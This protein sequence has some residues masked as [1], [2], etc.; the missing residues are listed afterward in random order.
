MDK[1][2]RY[3]LTHDEIEEI[4]DEAVFRYKMMRFMKEF[5]SVPGKVLVLGVSQGFQ[6]AIII[7]LMTLFLQGK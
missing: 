1:K 4:K 7:V 6:W 3:A 5:K 2:D